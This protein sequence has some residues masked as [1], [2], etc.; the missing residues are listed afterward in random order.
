MSVRRVEKRLIND[1][2]SKPDKSHR[3]RHMDTIVGASNMHNVRKRSDK[4]SDTTEQTIVAEV[5]TPIVEKA[6]ELPAIQISNSMA[7]LTN[8]WTDN[9]TYQNISTEG[10]TVGSCILGLNFINNVKPSRFIMA[11]NPTH[12]GIAEADMEKALN[13]VGLKSNDFGAFVKTDEGAFLNYSEF[14][15]PLIKSVQT[16]SG[17]VD[18]LKA[19]VAQ[20]KSADK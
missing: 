1:S 14:V 12:Y 13:T 9:G 4:R 11:G 7:P 15:A 16:L 8:I 6:I 5:V 18:S 20:L 10:K 17:Q 19:Q 2:T 3:A